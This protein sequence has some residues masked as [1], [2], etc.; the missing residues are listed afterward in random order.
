MKRS[1]FFL[2]A[3]SLVTLA[4]CEKG[5]NDANE[6]GGGGGVITP[7]PPQTPEQLILGRWEQTN[8][9]VELE[10]PDGIRT[11]LAD[12]SANYVASSKDTGGVYWKFNSDGTTSGDM[13]GTYNLD[14]D[15]NA[16]TFRGTGQGELNFEIL[17]IGTSSFVIYNDQLGNM[18]SAMLDAYGTE[19]LEF[20]GIDLDLIT[21][22]GRRFTHRKADD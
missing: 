5:S 7:P 9:T 3:L 2:F 8:V 14:A 18:K 15:G 4:A 1:L 17:T 11:M 22:Y 13:A 21:K 10:C 16:L 20:L 12:M 19:L 6:G